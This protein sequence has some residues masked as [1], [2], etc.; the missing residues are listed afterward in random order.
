M[1][2]KTNL[3]NNKQKLNDSDD[4]IFSI[5]KSIAIVL[6]AL[7]FYLSSTPTLA[8]TEGPPTIECE[9]GANTQKLIDE[10]TQAEVAVTERAEYNSLRKTLDTRKRL[11]IESSL[12]YE[13]VADSCLWRISVFVDNNTESRRVLSQMYLVTRSGQVK[14]RLNPEGDFVRVQDKK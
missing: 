5:M 3:N 6:G 13:T 4:Y 10:Q 14:Y 12:G 8:S 11:L 9:V 7:L 1:S 2:T